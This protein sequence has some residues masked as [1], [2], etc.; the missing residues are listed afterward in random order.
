MVAIPQWVAAKFLAGKDPAS[1]NVGMQYRWVEHLLSSCLP[2]LLSLK[3]LSLLLLTENLPEAWHILF[4][5]L[6]SH[7]ICKSASLCT[8]V[9][10]TME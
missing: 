4:I 8:S 1:L 3:D 9:C 5:F 10:L 6:V 2:L 7:S